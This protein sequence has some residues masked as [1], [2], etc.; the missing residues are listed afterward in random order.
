[1]VPS[2]NAEWMSDPECIVIVAIHE[3]LGMVGGIRLERSHEGTQ[4]PIE[5]SLEKLAPNIG[6][7]IAAL[8][9]F[10]V[11]EVCGMWNAIRFAS[12]GLPVLLGQAVTALSW[13]TGAQKMV[14][15]V[16]HYTQKH[17]KR[18]GFVVMESV[19][20]QG[21]FKQYPIPEIT[22]I[23][24]VHKDTVL[25]EHCSSE[26]RHLLYSLRMRP[27]Q[28]RIETPNGTPMEVHYDLR[29]SNSSVDLRTYRLVEE[30]HLRFSALER[31][32]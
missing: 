1:M 16:A 18:N 9:S 13:P 19:G 15:F 20:E 32:A 8:R 30:E 10:G 6:E 21:V 3:D 28:V 24:M 23:A 26:Q 29:V 31:R 7:E 4:L 5:K 17:P 27:T 12:K 25:L 14:C 2:N 11:S 22:A